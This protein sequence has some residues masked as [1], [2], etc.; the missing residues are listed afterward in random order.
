[1]NSNSC[2]INEV[3]RALNTFKLEGEV[4]S[5]SGRGGR[6]QR[7]VVRLQREVNGI[8]SKHCFAYP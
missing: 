7:E 8:E 3:F 5:L 6:Q 1:M 2:I 4:T